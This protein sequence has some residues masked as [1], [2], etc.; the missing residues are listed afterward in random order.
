[1]AS[2][3]DA[4][5]AA[6]SEQKAAFAKM[7]QWQETTHERIFGGQQPGIVQYLHSADEKLALTIET[8][9]KELMAALNAFRESVRIEF[10]G[11]KS[12][13][14]AIKADVTSLQNDKKIHKAYMAGGVAAGSAF[15]WLIKA[16]LLKIGIHV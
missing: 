2:K 6:Q 3:I 7:Q 1:M 12:E 11:V 16:G 8:S 9:N 15:G 10:A 4:V 13:S 5:L 14:T